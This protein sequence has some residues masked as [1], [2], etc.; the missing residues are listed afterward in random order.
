MYY[1]EELMKYRD[2]MMSEWINDMN[3]R[4]ECI[5]ERDG[6]INNIDKWSIQKMNH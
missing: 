6:Q 3:D 2:A 1:R 4:E 5:N